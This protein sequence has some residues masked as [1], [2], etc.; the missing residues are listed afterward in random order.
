MASSAGVPSKN[1]QN[2]STIHEVVQHVSVQIERLA[3][4]RADG[5]KL[6]TDLCRD[7]P[8]HTKPREVIQLEI[9]G[10]RSLQNEQRPQNQRSSRR[11]KRG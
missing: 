4:L 8:S 3:K 6:A 2:N 11:K 5:Q 7:R 1:A 10:G 9:D